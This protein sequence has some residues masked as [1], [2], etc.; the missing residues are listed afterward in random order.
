MKVVLL[1]PPGAGKGTQA[2][3][4]AG[5]L[6]VTHVS[7]GDLFRQAQEAGTELGSM[8]RSFM[9][10]GVLVPDDVTIRMMMDWMK[11]PDQAGGFVLD[12]FPRNLAQAQALDDGLNDRGGIDRVVYISVSEDELTRRLT[13]RRLCRRCQASYHQRFSPPAVSGTCDRCGGK[14]YQREDDTPEAVRERVRV[15]FKE[16][17][18][19]IEYY[20]KARTLEEVEGEGSIEEVAK[21]LRL[22]VGRPFR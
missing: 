16:T 8:A 7:S 22:A 2:V 3:T 18:P 4:L 19:L 10:R 20:R 1:G 12:G 21:A 5:H 13:G 15:Y 9:V 11:E 6:G 14:L 17:E